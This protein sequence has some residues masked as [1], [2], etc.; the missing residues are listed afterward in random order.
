MKKIIVFL[1]IM[2][3]MITASGCTTPTEVTKD[4]DAEE[5]KPNESI[6]FNNIQ[7]F[8]RLVED[9]SF[10]LVEPE[11]LIKIEDLVDQEIIDHFGVTVLVTGKNIYAYK[12]LGGTTL[13]Y[14]IQYNKFASINDVM[15]TNAKYI[16][17]DSFPDIDK[18]SEYEPSPAV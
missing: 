18:V 2:Y 14:F 13:N 11:A 17:T 6:V 7:D 3:V 10:N 5:Y 15:G 16:E 9:G 12:F 4:E 8:Y 1:C